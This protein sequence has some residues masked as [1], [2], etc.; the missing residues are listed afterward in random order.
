VARVLSLILTT[1]FLSSCSGGGGGAPEPAPVPVPTPAPAMDFSYEAP[2]TLNDYQPFEITV[3]PSNLQTGE[4][5]EVTVEDVD[6]QILFLNI[7]E[8]TITGRAPFTY[9]SVDLDFD[10][11]LT[12]SNNR[13]VTKSILIPVNFLHVAEEF[14]TEDDQ[15]AFNPAQDIQDKLQNENYAV[16]DIMPWYRGER[17]HIPEGTYCYA[18]S[19]TVVPGGY[20]PGFMPGPIR[21]GDFDGDG[22]QDVIF[23]ADPNSR[24]FKAIGAD[25]DRSYWSSIH[26]LFND[27]A[28]RLSEDYSKYDGGEPPRIP[29]P[30]EVRVE[31]FNSDGI[32]DA[33]I[34]SYGFP[35]ILED[36]TN[37]W[38]P[39]PHLVLLSNSEIHT[40]NFYPQ[41]EPELQDNLAT[42][43]RFAHDASSGDVDGDGDI[44]FFMN[45]VLYFNDGEG[46]FE[47]VDL[48]WKEEVFPCCIEK[49]KI[50]KNHAHTSTM[51]D[52]NG[53]GIDD[54]A[55]FWSGVPLDFREPGDI[56]GPRNH[57][58]ILLGPVTKDNPV[59]LDNEKWKT[60]PD[61]YF[62][63]DKGFWNTADS[64][65]IDGD[66]D[67][68]IVV[69][70]VRGS[71]YYAGTYVQV[72]ISNGDGTF[73]D[74][75]SVRFADQPRA[76]LSEDI[77]PGSNGGGGF[78]SLKDVDQ[79]GDLDIVDTQA[80]YTGTDFLI[81]PRVTLALNDGEGVFEEV[82]FDYFP[83]RM[84]FTYFD[85][86]LDLG[87]EEGEAELIH[88]SGVVDLDGN[89][90]LD[91]VSHLYGATD[92]ATEDDPEIKRETF[93]TTQSYIS[94]KQQVKE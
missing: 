91:F 26:I 1:V 14:N 74:E 88:R 93:V 52:F 19:C 28:G 44:D 23:F 87:F 60:L 9:T 49:V 18:G 62:G 51:G 7:S 15:L 30:Y 79:D 63:P 83:K 46:K 89:G 45:A 80:I 27:G 34:A 69:K 48:N 36:N 67:E 24:R 70:S 72:F 56:Y 22:D 20:P 81:F 92:R 73:N 33:A 65:D 85:N 75:S 76:A 42:R 17:K 5:V 53:D 47:I 64:G 43:N 61:N 4:T 8:N 86:F 84:A 38:H 11:K 54:L 71:P 82:P 31:D 94:K 6:N 35:E 58:N 78:I 25:Q 37:I 13:T 16:W 40:N 41:N 77:R 59:M 57:S 3:T 90:H 32:D 55:I 39:Y 12:S 10:V 66:G 21:A 68:D 2:E 50:D 29:Y